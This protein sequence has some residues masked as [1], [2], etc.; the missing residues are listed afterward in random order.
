MSETR[1]SNVLG[2]RDQMK[3]ARLPEEA[4][5]GAEVYTPIVTSFLPL[6]GVSSRGSP[7][8]IEG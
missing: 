2:P 3:N 8:N 6:S 7:G 1:E 5:R 4:G